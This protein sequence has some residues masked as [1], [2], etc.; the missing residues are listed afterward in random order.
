MDD[1]YFRGW[2]GHL[3]LEECANGNSCPLLEQSAVVDPITSC[4][5]EKQ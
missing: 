1:S 3:W 4:F 2:R 5:S